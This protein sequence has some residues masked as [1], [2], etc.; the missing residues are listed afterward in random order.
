[1]SKD[2]YWFCNDERTAGG[3]F[4]TLEEAEAQCLNEQQDEGGSPWY[5]GERKHY[6]A[7][8]FFETVHYIFENMNE[9]AFDSD[10]DEGGEWLLDVKPEH[11]T[12]LQQRIRK[13]INYW[14]T[15]HG[16]HPKFWTITNEKQCKEW[17][18]ILP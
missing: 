16:Y 15:K 18:E 2:G 13:V 1:M 5:V 11:A 8:D 14:A 17:D 6:Q 9:R 12:E 7:G 10:G 3:P 4:M